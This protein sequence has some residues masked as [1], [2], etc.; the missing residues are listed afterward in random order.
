ME[1]SL[2]LTADGWEDKSIILH[3]GEKNV[4]E[5]EFP[6]HLLSGQSPKENGLSYFLEGMIKPKLYK[7]NFVR[8]ICCIGVAPN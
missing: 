4:P 7:R 2:Q 1:V 5:P 8:R 6:H 3:T